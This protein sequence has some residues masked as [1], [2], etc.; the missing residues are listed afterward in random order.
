VGTTSAESLPPPGE[1]P[2]PTETVSFFRKP[3]YLLLT[4]A[5]T[6]IISEILIM[7]AIKQLPSMGFFQEALLDGVLLSFIVFPSLYFLVFKYLNEQI[8]QNKLLEDEL[9]KALGTANAA[10]N[11][12]SRLLRTVAHEFRTPLGLLTGST[13]ILDRYWDRL[14][15]EK[16]FEQNE[17]IRSAAHQIST[18]VNSVI[19]F[20]QLGTDTAGKSPQMLDMEKNCRS[21]VAEVEAVWSTGQQCLVTIDPDCGVVLLDEILFRRLLENLLTNAF[22]YT[23]S[24]GSVSLQVSL[25]NRHVSLEITDTGI[26]IPPAD[27]AMIFEEFYRSGNVEGRRGLGLGLS[28][29]QEALSQMNGT[30]TLKSNTGEGTI[31]RV[32]IPEVDH[33]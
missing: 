20:N 16:R 8:T 14:T 31:I 25:K 11:T 27:Q 19:A 23:P 33:N 9:R 28:I 26:G 29:V 12:M 4:T 18:L 3:S 13:D 24:T 2:L 7:T 17:H 6:I 32:E 5:G 30:I 21:I 10:N 1:L 15:T 22:R